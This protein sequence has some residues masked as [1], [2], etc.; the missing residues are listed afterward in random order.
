MTLSLHCPLQLFAG[1][2][3]LQLAEVRLELAE[4]R[5]E[6]PVVWLQPA[7]ARLGLEGARPE[8]TRMQPELAGS[9]D[10]KP[11]VPLKLVTV[12]QQQQRAHAQQH[13]EAEP[14]QWGMVWG[15]VEE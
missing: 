14:L 15:A 4:L 6:P 1:W 3:R 11:A 2:P 13:L 5:L 12:Q 8:L 7:G 9:Q 10:P